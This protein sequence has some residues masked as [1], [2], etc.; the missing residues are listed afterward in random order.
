MLNFLVC[1]IHILP[2]SNLKSDRSRQLSL[3]ESRPEPQGLEN[4]P[5][6]IEQIPYTLQIGEEPRFWIVYDGGRVA[7]QFYQDEA[8]EIL[9]VTHQWDWSPDEKGR[10]KCQPLLEV[11]L[12]DICKATAKRRKPNSSPDIREIFPECLDGQLVGGEG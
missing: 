10:P 1:Q 12:N 5:P 9:R 3:F 6:S 2:Q 8:E 7:G 4:F 11:L